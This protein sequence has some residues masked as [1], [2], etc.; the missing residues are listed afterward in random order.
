M[1]TSDTCCYS[2]LACTNVWKNPYSKFGTWLP[3]YGSSHQ[4]PLAPSHKDTQSHWGLNSVSDEQLAQTIHTP[5]SSCAQHHSHVH[6]SHQGAPLIVDQTSLLLLVTRWVP[7]CGHGGL[8]AT[9][10]NK[11]LPVDTLPLYIPYEPVCHTTPQ[12]SSTGQTEKQSRICAKPRFCLR[13]CHS[14]TANLL[15][16]FAYTEWNNGTRHY[17]ILKE[18]KI[19]I[20]FPTEFLQGRAFFESIIQSNWFHKRNVFGASE[21]SHC[22]CSKLRIQFHSLLMHL[23]RP[24]GRYKISQVQYL[25]KKRPWSINL[26]WLLWCTVTDLGMGR[27]LESSHTCCRE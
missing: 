10:N 23:Q 6:K 15:K 16:Q 1:S 22:S 26:S 4:S 13:N 19:I 9:L 17:L 18:L 20:I 3:W 21:A 5:V 12:V 14:K 11:I 24:H 25:A 8:L 2:R 7:C 27:R